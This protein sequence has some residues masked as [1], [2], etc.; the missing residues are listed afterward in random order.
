MIQPT[1]A[2]NA[3]GFKDAT[4]REDA[5]TMSLLNSLQAVRTNKT[6]HLLGILSPI[7][8]LVIC[9]AVALYSY[10]NGIQLSMLALPIC[11]L[12]VYAPRVKEFIDRK[13]ESSGIR[14]DAGAL[15]SHFLLGYGTCVEKT[16]AGSAYT[17]KVK[18]QNGETL[19]GV[20]MAR[21]FYERTE[22]GKKLFVA[23]A[24]S[25]KAKQLIGV[26]PTLYDTKV[27]KERGEKESVEKPDSRKMRHISDEERIW[28]AAYYRKN[29]QQLLTEQEKSRSLFF[30]LPAAFC[31]AISFPLDRVVLMDIALMLLA[32]FVF[33]VVSDILEIRGNL[34][35]LRTDQNIFVQNATVSAKHVITTNQATSKRLPQPGKTLVIDF[36]DQA[37]KLVCRSKKQEDIRPLN[38]G[39]EVLLVYI[40]KKSPLAC[41]KPPRELEAAAEQE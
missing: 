8:M 29:R 15:G 40:G 27:Y 41:R 39:D 24:D 31:A 28:A 16:V 1:D 17:A 36:R 20:L 38:V 13:R 3:Y 11:L 9:A 22:P 7:F 30:L 12:M 21:D 18:L 5:L 4:E 37:G 2:K 34:K 19:D 23:M 25:P 35:S 26:L 14:H 6:M 33:S 10:R 32:S